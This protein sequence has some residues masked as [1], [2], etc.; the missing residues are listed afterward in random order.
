MNKRKSKRKKAQHPSGIS[1]MRSTAM[2]QPLALIST[3]YFGFKWPHLFPACKG[4]HQVNL[5]VVW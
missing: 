3:H 4:T 2:Q 1:P 5:A